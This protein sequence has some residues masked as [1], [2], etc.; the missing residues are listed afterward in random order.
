MTTKIFPWS[1]NETVRKHFSDVHP[2]EH[3]VRETVDKKVVIKESLLKT[4]AGLS[5]TYD[6]RVDRWARQ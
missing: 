5:L 1:F 3:T 2:E 6:D 4:P